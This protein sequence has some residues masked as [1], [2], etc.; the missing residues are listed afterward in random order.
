MKRL[1]IA[2]LLCT[3]AYAGK[4]MAECSNGKCVISEADWKQFQEFHKQTRKGVEDM[5]AHIG[6]QSRALMG[7]MGKLAACQAKQ[8]ER[9]V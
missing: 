1:L 3:P 2:F 8:P 6:E 5:Q 7:M 4:P 9:E